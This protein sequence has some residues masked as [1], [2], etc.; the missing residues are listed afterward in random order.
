[1]AG[2]GGEGKMQRC[3]SGTGRDGEGGVVCALGWGE[4]GRKR[5]DTTVSDKMF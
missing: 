4:G 5:S 2:A 3:R 1:M